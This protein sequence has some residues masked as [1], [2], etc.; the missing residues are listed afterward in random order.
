MKREHPK[1]RTCWVRLSESAAVNIRAEVVTGFLYSIFYESN[2]V[3]IKVHLEL[4]MYSGP[5]SE[6]SN[7]DIIT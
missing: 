2:M 5:E 7:K 6:H 1:K 4:S 3:L